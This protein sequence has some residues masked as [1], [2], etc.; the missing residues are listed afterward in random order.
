MRKPKSILETELTEAQQAQLAD[1][2]LGGMIYVEAVP[3]IEKQFG[4]KVS[5]T[6]VSKFWEKVCA[7]QLLLRRS[8][9]VQ[10]ANAIGADTPESQSSIDKAMLAALKQKAFEV[11]VKPNPSPEEITSVLSSALKVVS[12]EGKEADRK[13]KREIQEQSAMDRAEDRKLKREIFEFDGAKAAIK[14]AMQIK[15][16][17]ANKTFTESEKIQKVRQLLFGVLPDGPK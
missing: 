3:V 6:A 9:A 1:W 17:V 7:P 10:L 4:L 15:T 16:I 13:L 12:E 14:N 8:K 2:L 5:K 11:L